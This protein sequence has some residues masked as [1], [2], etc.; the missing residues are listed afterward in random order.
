M[1]QSA[2][3]LV[4]WP[5]S[6]PLPWLPPA[7]H[8]LWPALFPPRSHPLS[9]P[10][11]D[12]NINELMERVSIGGSKMVQGAGKAVKLLGKLAGR[13]SSA[14]PAEPPKVSATAASLRQPSATSLM[15]P[16]FG[17]AADGACTCAG[18]QAGMRTG[19]WLAGRQ[20]CAQA[21]AQH[22]VRLAWALQCAR[23]ASAG[24]DGLF[25]IPSP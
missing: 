21:A 5:R 11:T 2:G 4:A 14:S 8:D 25:C 24:A 17:E 6:L 7:M 20:A 13:L 19:C 15:A 18:W 10:Q 3:K 23:C 22:A 12:N 16:V 9:S 1:R